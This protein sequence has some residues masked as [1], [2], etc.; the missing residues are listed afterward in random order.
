M[1]NTKVLIQGYQGFFHDV[2]CQAC[3]G[4]IE[5]TPYMY[6]RCK[7]VTIELCLDYLELSQYNQADISAAINKELTSV[8]L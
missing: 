6:E 4:D 7:E 2:A 8:M 5:E 1:K 3:F